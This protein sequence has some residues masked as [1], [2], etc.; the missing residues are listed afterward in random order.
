MA[1][2]LLFSEKGRQGQQWRNSKSRESNSNRD[3]GKKE[4]EECRW[5]A[6]VL[7][8]LLVSTITDCARHEMKKKGKRSR[9]STEQYWVAIKE[10]KLSYY[11]G[12]TLLFTLPTHYGNLI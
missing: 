3:N 4:G 7:V 2:L 9:N 10:L 6:V 12:E 11:I 5:K 8:R 1:F